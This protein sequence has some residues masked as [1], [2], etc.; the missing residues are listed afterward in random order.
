LALLPESGRATL[1]TTWT[2]A[3][4]KTLVAERSAKAAKKS[5]RAKRTFATG[6]PRRHG[7]ARVGP[8]WIAELVGT[9][10]Y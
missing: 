9:S 4:S 6:T 1:N 7:R 5:K 3:R 8:S 10:R 2:L